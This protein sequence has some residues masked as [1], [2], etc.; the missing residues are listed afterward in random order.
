MLGIVGFYQNP[1]LS[2]DY[3]APKKVLLTY[4]QEWPMGIK[5]NQGNQRQMLEIE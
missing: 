1:L 3:S 2:F 5:G 4:I